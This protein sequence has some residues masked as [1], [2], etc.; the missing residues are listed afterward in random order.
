[1]IHWIKF[2]DCKASMDIDI[3]LRYI[4][5]DNIPHYHLGR[6]NNP[7]ELSPGRY[8]EEY[9]VLDCDISKINIYADEHD[10]F[11]WTYL[12]S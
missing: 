3:L 4:D 7:W 1:M 11:S 8:Q 6:L 10:R 9:F 2:S 12:S 5:E